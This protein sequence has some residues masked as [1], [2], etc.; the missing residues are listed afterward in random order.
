MRPAW[1]ASRLETVVLFNSNLC[2][3]RLSRATP[4]QVLRC[5]C[6]KRRGRA[7]I[8][9]LET[10]QYF[11]GRVLQPCIRLVE[12]TRSLASQLTELVAI[13]HMRECPKN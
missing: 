1:T 7:W 6:C 11:V 8:G 3:R 4:L 5:L 10:A 9:R 12:F 13:G 2:E